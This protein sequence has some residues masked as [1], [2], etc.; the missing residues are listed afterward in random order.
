[1][2]WN[3]HDDD[4]P[5]PETRVELN[6]HGIPGAAGRV[7]LRH[8]RIDQTHSNAYTAWK[9]L[10]SPQNPTLEQSMTLEAAGQLQ[11]LT[12]P[13]WIEVQ[14]G[15]VELNFKLPRHAISLLH[16]SW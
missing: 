8:Y 9:S 6:F 11:E 4:V 15:R 7:L 2:V 16:L 3:Y 5:G 13:E 10:G 12:S 14:G 1:M